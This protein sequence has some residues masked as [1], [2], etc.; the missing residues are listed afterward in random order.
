MN[1]ETPAPTENEDPRARI[2]EDDVL[3]RRGFADFL[4]NA[5]TEQTRAVSER[6][7]RGLTVALDAAWGTGKTFFV[8]HWAD[9]LKARGH[10]VVYFDAWE[11]DL[12]E[13]A[14]IA[15]MAAI[16]ETIDEWV[17]RMPVKQEMQAR[18]ND[19][20]RQGVKQLR[21]AVVPV[22]K[23]MGAAVL[24][25]VT[26]IGV[27]E[28]LD[29]F[30]DDASSEEKEEKLSEEKIE[31]GLDKIFESALA[32]QKKRSEAITGFKSTI[33]NALEMIEQDANAILPAFVFVD[34]LDRCRP[35]YAIRLLEEIKHIFGIRNVCF[36]LS[37]NLSQIKESVRAIY[38]PSFDGYGY[39]KRFFDASYC[40]PLKHSDEKFVQVL[41]DESSSFSSNEGPLL[42]GFN[43]E[44]AGE[45]GDWPG[46]SINAIFSLFKLDLRS[47]RQVFSIADAAAASLKAEEKI[48]LVWLFFLAVAVYKFPEEYLLL[49][50]NKQSEDEFISMFSEKS[51][52]QQISHFN[53]LINIELIRIIYAYYENSK[54]E[55]E[56][57][58]N[59]MKGY[60]RSHVRWQVTRAII[61]PEKRGKS[62]KRHYH[63]D[64]VYI[65]YIDN[66]ISSYITLVEYSG[67][68]SEALHL[69][70]E[71]HQ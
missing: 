64:D 6:Q 34:E 71:E 56:D 63:H 1:D 14:A 17:G 43:T 21:R 18:A 61:T 49:K 57:C 4:T 54:L 27:K 60:S 3:D 13:E 48:H 55:I 2:W 33:S 42:V 38:G 16:K 51:N 47:Q 7:Q 9:D 24:K 62:L 10:P 25:K 37:T 31:A 44:L 20:V 29:A 67:F 45:D 40:L 65:T 12:G 26:G 32:E 30:D 11:N 41:L 68:R 52:Y 36:M 58:L 69:S 46:E 50:F 5:L 15:L 70:S 39:L 59:N 19:M 66:P 53:S 22:S 28:V 23:V 35:P 8:K